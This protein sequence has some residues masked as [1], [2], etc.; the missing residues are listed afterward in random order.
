[1]TDEDIVFKVERLLSRILN[2]ASIHVGFIY[3]DARKDMYQ[4]AISG[5]N[6]RKIMKLVVPHM[7]TR[8]RV[9]IWQS[10]NRYQQKKKIVDIKTLVSNM[11]IRKVEVA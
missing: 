8:R 7:G 10:L 9:K 4:I 1:M 11:S 3:R 5:D 2:K 6:A